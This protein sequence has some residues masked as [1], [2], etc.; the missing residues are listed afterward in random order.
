MTWIVDP[1]GNA[2]ASEPAKPSHRYRQVTLDLPQPLYDK[3]R[4]VHTALARSDQRMPGERDFV[5]YLIERGLHS[6]LAQA[7]AAQQANA[8]I[9]PATTMP[10]P[11][12]QG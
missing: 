9:Q 2:V 3:V 10:T 6:L 1:N 4:E 8:L 11:R 7:A 12:T 5:I